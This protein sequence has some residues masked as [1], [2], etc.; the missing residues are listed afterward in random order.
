[1][2]GHLAKIV[3]WQDGF[4]ALMVA[5]DS[6][7]AVPY[8]STDAGGIKKLATSVWETEQRS[9]IA[10]DGEMPS[11][12]T[13]WLA[14]SGTGTLVGIVE[15]G[16][17]KD[18]SQIIKPV[19]DF[20]MRVVGVTQNEDAEAQYRVEVVG[21][22]SGHFVTTVEA[23]LFGSPRSLAPW[24]AGH[25][26]NFYEEIKSVG[27]TGSG[28]RYGARLGT[29][30]GQQSLE[31]TQLRLAPWMGWHDDAGGFVCDEGVITADGLDLHAGW[32]PDPA[33]HK[34]EALQHRYGFEGDWSEAQ[35]ILREVLTFQD[36]MVTAVFGA[37]WAAILVKAQLKA[38]ASLFPFMAI[39]ATSGT[40]K[41]TGFFSLMVEL[42]GASK[43]G[44]HQTPAARRDSIAANRSGIVWIDDLDDAASTYQD[45]R[46]ATAEQARDKKGANRFGTVSVSLVAP[47]LLTGETL[48]GL[49][50][51][52]ALLDR[53]IQLDVPPAKDRRS[54]HGDYAQWDDIVRLKETYPQLWRFSGHY[55]Q[56]A[57]RHWPALVKQWPALRS[58]GGGRHA[59][60]LAILRMGARLLDM[61]AEAGW[62]AELVDDWCS[63][64]EA[65]TGDYLTNRILPEL[66][67]ASTGK[68][69]LGTKSAF[70][71]PPV[72][73]DEEGAIWWHPG[74][75][76]EAWAH[77]H[78]HSDERTKSFGTVTVLGRHRAAMGLTKDD[79]KKF[80]I[81][82]DRQPQQNYYPVPEPYATRIAEVIAG[83]G[84]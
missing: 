52:T 44:S 15:V 71:W 21:Q 53:L 48:P 63:K 10:E 45:I 9:A 42:N 29:Y 54:L 84:A 14:S 43:L 78:K 46:T 57:L 34:R 83:D 66:L 74:K 8:E 62:Y 28:N 56:Q 64:Q 7:L 50:D 6:G 61:M 32:M 17:G 55:V 76:A 67:L 81:A 12:E 37:W 27:S 35:K 11:Q 41:T 58:S 65:P 82:K 26:L 69:G 19:S 60:K 31:A 38:K 36:D 39:E 13:G 51:Q 49:A 22:Q 23:S 77:R 16:G 5:I 40:G 3:P 47:V 75:V 68:D 79:R 24:L 30:L 59:D 25:R 2:A 18:R 1:V 80:S 20:D 72:F 73:V 33:I 4:E 70:G